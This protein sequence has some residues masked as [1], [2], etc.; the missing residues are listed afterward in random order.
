[1]THWEAKARPCSRPA[2][3]R[4]LLSVVCCSLAIAAGF[5]TACGSTSAPT[6]P[7]D[8]G[9]DVANGSAWQGNDCHVCYTE[10]CASALTE[11]AYDPSCAAFRE[12]V[13]GCEPSISGTPDVGCLQACGTRSSGEE[14]IGC[15]AEA[16][17]T[18]EACGGASDAG[19]DAA[20]CGHSLLCQSCSTSTDTNPCW[21]CQDENCCESD[22]ACRDDPG[23]LAYFNC[24]QSC[25]LDSLRACELECD[26]QVG[27][28]HFL[29]FNMKLSCVRLYC[30][31]PSQC[32]SE[33]LTSC[34]LCLDDRCARET[35]ECDSDPQC[36]RIGGCIANCTDQACYDA[37]YQRYAAGV[38]LF[39]AS[40]ECLLAECFE[41]C[42]DV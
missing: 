10:H 18:C 24:I 32:G 27:A 42:S 16:E 38:P 33:P 20:E 17:E 1:M 34:E 12:C 6:I 7:Q 40:T 11:C 39:N 41:P 25:A 31:D 13:D 19:V 15:L 8:A 22:Q 36:A 30:G 26:E 9:P 14:V 23:C 21:K 28:E 4:T 29:K 2:R 35:V 3:A 37:C 5:G